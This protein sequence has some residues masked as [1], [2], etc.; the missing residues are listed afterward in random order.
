MDPDFVTATTTFIDEVAPHQWAPSTQSHLRRAGHKFASFCAYLGAPA[1]FN[2]QTT[3]AEEKPTHE[4]LREEELLTKFAFYL[5]LTGY[6]MNTTRG[7]VSAVRSL[8]SAYHPTSS[9]GYLPRFGRSPTSRFLKSVDG[10]FVEK[11]S[12]KHLRLGFTTRHIRQ[13]V[14]FALALNELDIAACCMIAFAGCFRLGELCAP[15]K[16]TYN[17]AIHVATSDVASIDSGAA[18]KLFMGPTKADQQALKARRHQRQFRITGRPIC[19]GTLLAQ[20]LKHRRAPSSPLFQD[21][22]G[23]QLKVRTMV[24]FARKA[25]LAYGMPKAETLLYKGH[26]FRIG[27]A[28]T[29]M[30]NGASPD[31]LRLLGAW[32]SDAY[33]RYLQQREDSFTPITDLLSTI[34]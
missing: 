20:L 4:R 33:R 24:N 29:A 3:T 19:A 30:L 8:Y 28:T 7:Y 11:A 34:D 17:P 16:R 18:L 22:H 6:A 32:D 1:P 9:F 25:L 26:S 27:A 10:F 21:H 13:I 5:L 15:R 31:Q 2:L 14:S 23:N 12:S